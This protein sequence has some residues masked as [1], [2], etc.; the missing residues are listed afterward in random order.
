MT[1]FRG[2]ALNTAALERAQANLPATRRLHFKRD[3]TTRWNSIFVMVKRCLTLLPAL[4]Q[5][6]ADIANGVEHPLVG[7]GAVV[8]TEEVIQRCQMFDRV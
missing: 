6:Q 5:L 3:C 8:P 2:S 7:L 1:F 4:R